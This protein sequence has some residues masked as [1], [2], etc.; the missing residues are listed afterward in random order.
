MNRLL[1]IIMLAC[2]LSISCS[3]ELKVS[4]ISV[5]PESMELPLGDSA[6]IRAAINFSGGNMNDPDLITLQW[7]S[8]DSDIATVD[9]LGK[10]KAK[11][12]GT[13]TI[14]VQCESATAQCVVNVTD[15]IAEE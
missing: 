1:Y 14:T 15:T 11:E 9:T 7:S 13:A 10:V 5:Y 8:D 6:R 12:I 2:A 3:N 4:S